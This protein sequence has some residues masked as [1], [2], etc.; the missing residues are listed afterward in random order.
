M[1]I[2]TEGKHDG[3]FIVSESNGTRSRSTG[4]L[5]SGEDLEAGTLLG[6][7]TTG[8]KLIQY[9]PDASTGEESVYAILVNNTDASSAD[10]LGVAIFIRDGEVNEAELTYNTSPTEGEITTA[11]TELA[12]LGIIVR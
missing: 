10:V 11:N 1:A 4:T 5:L 12:A 2:L 6:Q 8:G 3:E 7:I 9:D